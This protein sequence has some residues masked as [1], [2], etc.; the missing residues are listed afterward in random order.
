VSTE[1]HFSGVLIRH[2][3]SESDGLVPRSEMRHVAIIIFS[4]L[5]L[6]ILFQSLFLNFF[7]VLFFNS[8]LRRCRPQPLISLDCNVLKDIQQHVESR[9]K[10]IIWHP[11]RYQRHNNSNV[12]ATELTV[13]KKST[14]LIFKEICDVIKSDVDR[15]YQNVFALF[16]L[17]SSTYKPLRCTR[18]FKYDRDKL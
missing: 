13:R 3:C 4:H 8:L 11:Q 9:E 5:T 18:W 12:H 2:S 6:H 16:H 15:N 1:F 17:N 10:L 7:C 14:H